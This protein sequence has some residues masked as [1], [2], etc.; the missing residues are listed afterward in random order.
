MQKELTKERLEFQ[1]LMR[2]W[3]RAFEKV[4]KMVANHYGVG[5]PPERLLPGERPLAQLI[6]LSCDAEQQGSPVPDYFFDAFLCLTR[7]T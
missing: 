6:G 3:F 2:E 1:Q 4:I 5:W 7:R